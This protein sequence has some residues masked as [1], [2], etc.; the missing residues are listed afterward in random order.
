MI[1]YTVTLYIL[2]FCIATI[3][4][5]PL[6]KSIG[7]GEWVSFS[8]NIHCSNNDLVVWFVNGSALSIIETYGLMFQTSPPHSYCTSNQ[9]G[10]DRI[11]FL[12]SNQT[13]EYALSLQCAVVPLCDVISNCTMRMCFSEDAFLQGN[14]TFMC[15]YY[16]TYCNTLNYYGLYLQYYMN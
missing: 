4:R 5:N 14:H 7:V 6:S 10:I 11:L 2:N 3:N 1:L 8:C 13:L 12:K 15:S 9:H 16:I